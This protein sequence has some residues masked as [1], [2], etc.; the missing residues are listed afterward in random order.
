M[1]RGMVVTVV[2]WSRQGAIDKQGGLTGHRLLD[3]LAYNRTM[4][5]RCA[6]PGKWASSPATASPKLAT[7]LSL[8]TRCQY[9][10]QTRRRPR[11]RHPAAW[12]PPP[13]ADAL[14]SSSSC[15]SH[16]CCCCWS[17]AEP[18]PV[19]W[20]A[21]AAA[22]PAALP[23]RPAPGCCRRRWCLHAQPLLAQPLLSCYAPC[24]VCPCPPAAAAP[25]ATARPA[26]LAKA[27][28]R[29][30]CR[31]KPRSSCCLRP[32][33]RL[34]A[35]AV[36]RRCRLPM[37]GRQ[38]PSLCRRRRCRAGS[39]CPR[40]APCNGTQHMLLIS[41]CSQ[42]ESRVTYTRFSALPNIRI[43]CTAPRARPHHPLP[44]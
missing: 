44:T 25:G 12:L 30:G 18:A 22:G 2:K 15:S 9:Q 38:L 32:R 39:S 31:G 16:P 7:H 19:V 8:Q 1:T 42:A 41:S 11:R 36:S 28:R 3:A 23:P 43:T 34:I 17:A 37:P 13:P 27:P 6:P 26:M 21:A 24:A 35:H 33:N 40:G 20:W 5:L 10:Q 29:A 4:H 14:S